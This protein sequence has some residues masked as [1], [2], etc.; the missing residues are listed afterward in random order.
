[1]LTTEQEQERRGYIG[2]SDAGTVLSW[3]LGL[4]DLAPPWQQPYDVWARLRGA[5]REP[6]DEEQAERVEWGSLLEEPIAKRY[7]A[8]TGWEVVRWGDKA[9][10]MLNMP[11]IGAL[12]DYQAI[13]APDRRLVEVKNMRF[14]KERE[15]PPYYL[16]QGQQQ[17]LVTKVEVMDFAVLVGGQKLEVIEM[18]ADHD[19]QDVL[20]EAL[21][22]F[23]RLV[24]ED[25]PPELQP[26]A[27][28]TPAALRAMFPGVS[29]EVKALTDSA[30]HWHQVR[31][32]AK[33][34]IKALEATAEIAK[35]RILLE[36]GEAGVGLLPGG[37]GYTRRTVSVA[38]YTR[39]VEPYEYVDFRFSQK[40]G[41]GK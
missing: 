33:A 31:E 32:Q 20:I 5:E 35:Q 39:T 14:L 2:A 30:R 37:G 3:Y 8:R 29:G 13:D 41:G 27:R 10:R 16:A 26:G 7:A 28:T 23:W 15:L 22:R 1:M 4:P 25:K 21:A 19:Y 12:P 18:A 40:A 38:G 24:Q 11:Y 6:M 36:M 9:A 17:L 34:E